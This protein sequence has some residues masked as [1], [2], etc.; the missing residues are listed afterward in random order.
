MPTLGLSVDVWMTLWVLRLVFG[1]ARD[2]ALAVKSAPTPRSLVGPG[3]GLGKLKINT[4]CLT[5]M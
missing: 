2:F 4:S 1:W 5:W 3:V